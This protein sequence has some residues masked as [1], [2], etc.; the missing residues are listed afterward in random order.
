MDKNNNMSEEIA[1]KFLDTHLNFIPLKSLTTFAITEKFSMETYIFLDSNFISSSVDVNENNLSMDE[2]LINKALTNGAIVAI[3]EQEINHNFHNYYYF[4]KNG[5]E[6]LRTP[7]KFDL[8]GR[9]DGN[10]MAKILFGK[11]LNNL[12][13]K[14]ALYILNEKNYEKSL[15]QFSKEFLE[16]KEE[17]C[18]CE[19]IF[20]EYFN[21]KFNV[22]ELSDYMA[23]NFKSNKNKI[24]Y[25]S[26][27]LKNDVLG[28]PNFDEN[29]SGDFDEEEF[30]L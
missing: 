10:N 16:L 27:K 2:E 3:N 9:E 30:Y 18:K 17:H 4:S 6:T 1:K 5:N 25:I 12:T 20:K 28:F 11:V 23:I 15:N 21:M 14:Q 29:L 19:G 8:N 7:R 22:K 24:G 13:L 26:I